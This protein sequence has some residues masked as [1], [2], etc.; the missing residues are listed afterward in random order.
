[1]NEFINENE[2]SGRIRVSKS[3]MASPFFFVQK[4]DGSLR[5]VQDYRKLNLMTVKNRYPLPLISEIVDELK[6]ARIFTKLDVRWGYNNVRI[7]EGDEWKAAFR[8]KR[9]LYEPL[10]M[11]FGLTNSPATFQTMMNT[12]LK[13]LILAGHVRVYMDDIL[14]FTKDLESHREI[15]AKVLQILQDNDL[16]LKPEKCTWEADKVEYLG[17]IVSEGTVEMDPVKVAAVKE[18]PTPRSKVE[19]QTFLG[20]VNFYRRF[21]REFGSIAKPL[22]RLTGKTPWNWGKEE[23]KAFEGLRDQVVAAPRLAIPQEGGKFRLETD[24]SNYAKGAVLY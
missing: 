6:D 8:C 3:P 4:K 24:A 7:K 14:I 9:G 12:L 15:V 5:P 18:W 16:Y 23:Q 17:L 1:M 20:F 13:D 22:T 10:V 21:L 11:F 19:V 2:K